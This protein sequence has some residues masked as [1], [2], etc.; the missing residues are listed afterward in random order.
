MLDRVKARLTY[1]NV[2]ATVAVFIALGGTS[3]AATALINGSKLKNRTVA[4][5]KLKNRTL[6][7]KKLKQNTVRGTEVRESTLD[8]VPRALQ[9]DDATTLDQLDSSAFLPRAAKAADAD[10][11][12]GADSS[13]FL[14]S[15]RIAAGRANQQVGT[16]GHV[17][18]LR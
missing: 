10:A 3:V 12:D 17:L 13:S 15:D 11:L 14:R 7:G 18:L 5:K 4:G 2:M 1:A 9:A 16:G 8:P 6:A